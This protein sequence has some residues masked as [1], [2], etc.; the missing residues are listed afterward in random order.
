[1]DGI[2]LPQKLGL[3]STTFGAIP[4]KAAPLTITAIFNNTKIKT[5]LQ[6]HSDILPKSI[7]ATKV[8]IKF[9]E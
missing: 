2:H 6:P 3:R 9:S 7:A 5:E 8:S 4:D 1:M